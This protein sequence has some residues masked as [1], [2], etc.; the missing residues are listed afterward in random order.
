MIPNFF[1]TILE[2]IASMRGSEF[3]GT[4]VLVLALGG[5]CCSISKLLLWHNPRFSFFGKPD[6]YL[7]F[8]QNILN[9]IMITK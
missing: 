7:I 8:I 2:C 1:K 9:S 3:F 4:F 5:L 6:L